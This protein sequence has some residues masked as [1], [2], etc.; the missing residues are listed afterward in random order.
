MSAAR[1]WKQEEELSVLKEM[2]PDLYQGYL[3]AKPYE[4]GEFE[5]YYIKE[6]SP[7]YKDCRERQKHFMELSCTGKE[8]NIPEAEEQENMEIIVE[9]M[10]EIV[11]CQRH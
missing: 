6:D 9:S 5:E 4:T 3:F 2:E 7:R 8:R 1:G 10:D 11:F